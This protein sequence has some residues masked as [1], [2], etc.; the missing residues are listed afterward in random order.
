MHGFAPLLSTQL[1]QKCSIGRAGGAGIALEA[2]K[3]AK[4]QRCKLPPRAMPV[5]ARQEHGAK[6]HRENL[7][8]YAAP[9]PDN[10]MAVFMHGYNNRQGDDKKEN[11]PNKSAERS[12][13]CS[14]IKHQL[15]EPFRA[16]LDRLAKHPVNHEARCSKAP[17]GPCCATPFRPV[18]PYLK[19]QYPLKQNDLRPLPWPH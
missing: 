4:R 6:S 16:W 10:V 17:R 14:H 18:S 5:H 15:S 13:E 1:W 2:H 3:S 12:R 8:M 11:H 7:R 19:I 9:T